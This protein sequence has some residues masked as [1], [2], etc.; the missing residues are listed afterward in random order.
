MSPGPMRLSAPDAPRTRTSTGDGASPSI[1]RPAG[2]CWS[3]SGTRRPRSTVSSPATTIHSSTRQPER[4]QS[5]ARDA[6]SGQMRLE[7][8]R[9]LHLAA[10]ALCRA[11]AAQRAQPRAQRVAVEAALDLPV[12][13]IE[14]LPVSSDTTMATESFSSVRPM[15]ARW[16]EPSSL[17]SFGFTVSGRKQAAAATRSSCTITAPSCSGD[18]GWKDAHEQVVGQHRVERDAALDV[19]AQA[20][21]PLDRDDRA[22]ALRRQHARRDDQLLDRLL[23]R[24]GLGEIPEERRAA[25]VRQRAADVGLEQHDDREDDVA[26]QVADQPVD[27]LEV[28]PP[29]PVEQRDEQRRRR[30]PSARRACRESA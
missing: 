30:A 23:R 16:R 1:S 9:V 28:A 3:S 24:L 26:E 29:R 10:A 18:D 4:Q 11:A 20:D 12:D 8:S 17:L 27:G 22:D 6:E 7:S 19:V 21:L 14:M 15:A 13:T 25:E 5:S 2:N